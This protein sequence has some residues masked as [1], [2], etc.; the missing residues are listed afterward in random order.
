MKRI[1]ALSLLATLTATGAAFAQPGNMKGMDMNSCMAMK[2]MNMAS[3][4][5]MMKGMNSGS[6]SQGMS[7]NGATHKA[8]ATVKSADPAKGVVT[9]AHGPVESLQWP[10]MT[11]TFAVKDK[12]LFDKLAVGRKVDVEFTKQGSDYIVTAVN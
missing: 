9:L 5:D 6:M 10:A 2:G 3:C 7:R 4:Q 8:S 1:A 12:A 11:M